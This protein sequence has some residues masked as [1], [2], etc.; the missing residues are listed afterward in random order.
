MAR[1]IHLFAQT[2]IV[3]L[4]HLIVAPTLM[5]DSLIFT[6]AGIVIRIPQG[7][8]KQEEVLKTKTLRKRKKKKDLHIS[9]HSKLTNESIRMLFETLASKMSH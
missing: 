4:L 2:I 7:P 8:T 6:Q 3:F 5:H 1:K 9:S